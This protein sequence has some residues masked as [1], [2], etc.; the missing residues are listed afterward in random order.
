MNSGFDP[1]LIQRYNTSG[2]RYTSYPTALQFH[3][4]EAEAMKQA[5]AA[6]PLKDNDISLYLHVPFCATLC[7]YCACNKYVTR[8]YDKATRY[9]ACLKAEL[10]Q[11]AIDIGQRKVSQIH[12][13]GGTP[14]FLNDRDIRSVWQVM[15]EHFNLA[16]DH[17]GEFG[18]EIDPRTVNPNR[19]EH[20]RQV[21]FNR[22]SM[23]IQDFDPGVQKAVNRIQSYGDTEAV[24]NAARQNGFE[25]I[26]VDLIYGLPLQ[27]VERFRR[28]LEQV[29]TLA[30]DRISIFNYA[31]LP[32]RFPPQRRINLEDMPAAETKLAIL[33]LCIEH[34]E[35]AGYVRIGMD[36]FAKPTDSLALALDAG[37][38]HRNFQGYST[39]AD[40][41]MF[42]F[43]M[44]AIS[45]IGHSY[46]QNSKDLEEYCSQ[47]EQ[48]QSA[49]KLGLE[50]DPDDQLRARI[51]S[52]LMC[53]FRVDFGA[54]GVDFKNYFA[55][56]LEAL[57]RFAADN[58][59][60]IGTDS[61]QVTDRGRLLVRNLC[62]VFD[63]H[64]P[65]AAPGRFS[66]A[67]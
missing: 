18:V 59:L 16:P 8:Q 1:A 5:I 55:N 62:M 54:Y 63:R 42:A 15:N 31:H 46:W 12:W 50:I 40:S 38:L 7:Y 58:L 52:D 33:E 66:K 53:Q 23:G 29:V 10:Q 64:L 14:T 9:I 45:K 30:P 24:F 13:G 49:V 39:F 67:L 25:S 35:A 34:L 21:G 44:T 20:L 27:T 6:S 22:L 36:H 48:G 28:T 47:I 65:S 26:S 17:E 51:I 3:D 43:G 11:A 57:G 2:P 37:E 41:D 4:V 61:L 56:E 19:V 60:N 32:D